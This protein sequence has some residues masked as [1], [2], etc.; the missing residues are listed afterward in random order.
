MRQILGDLARIPAHSHPRRENNPIPMMMGAIHKEFTSFHV[1]GFWSTRTSILS[2][3]KVH[4]L[5]GRDA[6]LGP[7]LRLRGEV[8]VGERA[9]DGGRLEEVLETLTDR[10]KNVLRLRFG[11]EDGRSRTLEE[12]GQSFGVTRERIRQIEAKALRKLRH[13]VRLRKLQGNF[14]L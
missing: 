8:L 13:P 14:D 6:G 1:N 9:A 10:E 11:L 4:A 12:V 2:S 7:R 3:A 5:P